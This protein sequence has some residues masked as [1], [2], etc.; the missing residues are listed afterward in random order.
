MKNNVAG[1]VLVVV[2][3]VF[4]F[5]AIQK[6]DFKNVEQIR[7]AGQNIEVDLALTK[8]D[9]R[10]GLGER[11]E[12]KENEGMLF[13]FPRPGRYPFWMKDMKFAI[14]IIWMAENRRVIYIK[15]DARP[16]SFLPAGQAGP[17]TYGPSGEAK[18]VLEVVAGFSDKNNLK[19]GDKAEFTHTLN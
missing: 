19:I 13:V 6:P 11:N 15:K 17:E 16:E 8:E 9:Q 7:I 12:L 14:D 1:F 3:S 5:A 4:L 10:I 18:Y 2:F